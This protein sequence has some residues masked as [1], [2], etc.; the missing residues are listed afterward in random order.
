LR[1][2]AV[3]AGAVTAT[4][5]TAPAAL[6]RLGDPKRPLARTV[7]DDAGMRVASLG[8]CLLAVAVLGA[9][10]G[11]AGA[12]SSGAFVTRSGTNLLLDGQPYRFGGANVEWLGLAGYGPADPAGPHYPSHY[13]IDDALATA[14]ELGAA[15][16]RS[17]TMGDSVGCA[18]CLEPALGRFNE[19]AFERIDYALASARRHGIR[20]VATLVGDDAADGGA[21]CVYLAWRGISV[22][23]CSL[24]NMDPFWSDPTVIGDVEQHVEAVLD[25]VNVYTHV[26]YRNDPTILGWDLVNGGGSPPSWTRA[27]GRFVRGIDRRHLV[28]SDASNARLSVVDAC[29]A[30]VYPHWR[31][32]LRVVSP[33]IAACRAAHKPF[34]A[35]EY[36]WDRTNFPTV[37]ALRSFLGT[38]EANPEVAGDAFWALQ[39]HSDGHGFM[40]IPADV[41]DPAAAARVESGEWWALY[42]PGLRTLVTP[43][44]DMAAR[45]QVLRGHN[46]AMR[47]LPAPPHALPPAPVVTSV[48]SGPAGSRVYWQGSA[49]AGRYSVERAR[50]ARGPW[51]IVCRRC[52]TDRAD[53]WLDRASA[54]SGAWYRVVPFNLDGKAGAASRPKRGPPA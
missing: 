32:P 44:A 7:P 18:P 53:G 48:V 10:S 25:H 14:R 26:A 16:V 54:A 12:G 35:Y 11:A 36:G 20:I 51:V 33:K 4:S 38:L 24:S 8:A 43:A 21:G 17:Q 13:E 5:A 31:L 29:V 23:G 45:A 19:A 1:A 52:V 37:R 49:G 47:G 15:V 46:Y 22:P 39:A 30:F 27:I 50:S 34:L 6:H 41:T 2:A 3:A 42:Y 28:L 9:G 40:P